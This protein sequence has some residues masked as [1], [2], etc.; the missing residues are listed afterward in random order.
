MLYLVSIV[1]G[2]VLGIIIRILIDE[3]C[4]IVIGGVSR[5]KKYYENVEKE[6]Q[7]LLKNR[8]PSTKAELQEWWDSS[9]KK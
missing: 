1:L 4:G 3:G 7:E 6:V 9:H 2:F 8:S 5:N